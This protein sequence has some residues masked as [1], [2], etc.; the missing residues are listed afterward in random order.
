MSKTNLYIRIGI[1][2]LM[3]LLF[4]AVL[5]FTLF[6]LQ[7]V[8]AA[9][10][11]AARSE[12]RYTTEIT[13]PA[14]RGEIFDRYGRPLVTN[15]LSYNITLNHRQMTI[16]DSYDSGSAAEGILTLIAL[17]RQENTGYVDTLPV[18]FEPYRYISEM[19]RSQE[20]FLARFLDEIEEPD[21]DASE[22]MELLK[23]RYRIPESFG[24]DDARL[25]VGV[26]YEMELRTLFFNIPP[27]VFA[28]DISLTLLKLI[29]ERRLP[30]VHINSVT[31]REYQTD[32]AA[33]LLG[34]VGPIFS[35]EEFEALRPLGYSLD[36]IV[37]R[38]GIEK[39]AEQWLR[40]VDGI[41]SIETT[42][43]GQITSQSYRREPQ[44]G[45]HVFTT[46]CLRLQ[47][48][49][50][51]ALKRGIYNLRATGEDR[52]GGAALGGAVVVLNTNTG[53]VLAMASYPT[54]TLSEF[55]QSYQELSADSL[56][57]M[58][59][60]AIAGIYAPG[61]IFKMCTGIAALE[62]GIV[63]PRT[64]IYDHG[65]YMYYAPS[66]TPRCHIFPGSHGNVNAATALKVSCNYYYYEIGRL[67]GIS[68][69]ADFASRMGLGRR[70]GIEIDGELPGVLA[71]IEYT[72]SR[73]LRWNAGDTIQA[74]I[75]QSYN[76]FT[77]LQMAVYTSTIANNGL[78]YRPH[79]IKSVRSYDFRRAMF[80]VA[81]EI[82][83][84]LEFEPANIKAIQ[85]GMRMAS[86][87]G[88]TAARIFAAY[89]IP[90]ASKTGTVQISAN[91][92]NDG[93]FVAYAPFDNPEI[94]VAVVVEKGAGGSRVAPI[95]RDVFTAYFDIKERM[96]R[97]DAE[98]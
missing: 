5:F 6:D 83:E 11:A 67:L 63:N 52:E 1:L 28:D 36:A 38:D 29:E 66:Y 8:Q 33:H 89:H 74:A 32:F 31:S 46:I 86:Q 92:P 55:N 88:G 82:L 95:A 15:R 23:D 16:A 81:P 58:I 35:E 24:E 43:S 80:D 60:R 47:E 41:L 77:P 51:R 57:P 12:R 44:A 50:E 39:A 91:R 62:H 56:R 94:A 26:R 25:V 45:N 3:T 9:P 2:G 40:G 13:V 37:G 30:G 68:R 79:L 19:T 7:L 59:N 75:G 22:L 14:A 10:E 96:V 48:A 64:T 20:Q 49:T 87:A 4:T 18:T 98:R 72:A 73:N 84:D 54:F 42:A 76:S 65:R 69:I 78:F 53:E 70:T 93:V 21:I 27:Y 34:R 97:A 17:C 90:V 85:D 71:S 61:S